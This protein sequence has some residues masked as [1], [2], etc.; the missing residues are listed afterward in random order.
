MNR[1]KA[2][3][4]NNAMVWLQRLPHLM[5]GD[6]FLSGNLNDKVL[7]TSPCDPEDHIRAYLTCINGCSSC[8]GYYLAMVSQDMQDMLH[9]CQLCV[10][11][12]GG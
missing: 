10:E 1:I 8:L 3:L 11:I 4:P 12:R 9:R 6:H 7:A 5:P 2:L